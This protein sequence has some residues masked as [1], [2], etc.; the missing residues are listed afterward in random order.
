MLG[1]IDFVAKC[2][3]DT[4]ISI[5]SLIQFIDIH[6]PTR[7]QIWE[8]RIY[9][10][11]FYDSVA[12]GG[13]AY[14][15]C[16]KMEK[17]FFMSGQFYFVSHDIVMMRYLW[18]KSFASVPYEDVDFGLRLWKGNVTFNAL[19]LNA[20][21]FWVHLLKEEKQYYSVFTQTKNNSWDLIAPQLSQ[22]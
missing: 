2:D 12:C 11:I 16:R 19:I 21:P 8:P 18:M 15:Q 14:E 9:G 6:L 13:P 3:L 17:R 1:D 7:Q 5:P 4:F 22:S 20:A 10:G